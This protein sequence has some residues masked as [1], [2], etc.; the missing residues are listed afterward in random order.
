MAWDTMTLEG[1]WTVPLEG[2]KFD[3]VVGVLFEYVGL[4]CDWERFEFADSVEKAEESEEEKE[5]VKKTKQEVAE[6]L[7]KNALALLVAATIRS[8][9]SKEAKKYLDKERAGIVMLRMP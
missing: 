9:D 2:E 4:C 8:K 3:G 1:L 7:T 6:E 5:R